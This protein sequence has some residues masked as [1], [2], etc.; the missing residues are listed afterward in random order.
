MSENT[1][2]A[3]NRCLR[4][5][6]QRR[7][8]KHLVGGL[9]AFARWF[10][11]LF[12]VLILIDRFTFLPG[13]ARAVIALAL[14]AVAGRQAWRHGWSRLRGFDATRTAKE[15]EDAQG[16]MDS[17]LVTAVQFQKSGASPGT[18]AAMWELTQRKAEAAAEE[19]P[20]EKVVNLRDLK[21]PIRI[22]AGLA[23]V[24][25]ILAILNG[26]FLAAG[27][28]RLFTPWLAIAYPTKTQ[29]DP[30]AEELVVKEGAPAKVE[31]RLSGSVPTTAKLELQTGE[32]RPR[33]LKLDVADGV[34]VYEIASA[35]RD[36]TYRVKAGDAR[37]DWRQVRV[38]PA[39]RLAEVKVD[40]EYPAYI[41]RPTE[42]VEALTLTVPEETTVRWKLTLD[43]PIQEATLHRDGAEDLPLEIG[44]DGR[45]LTLSE[46]ASASRGYSFSW[47]EAGHGFD[48]T[49]PRY[50]LQVASDQAPRVELT[51]PESNLNAMLGRPLE[52]AVRAQDDHGIGTTTITYRVNRRPEKTI[53][54]A[55]PVRSGE[56]SQA[57]GW[58]YREELPDLQVGDSVS[59]LVEVT[60]KYPGE[61]GPYRARTDSRRIT[62]L[63]RDEYLAAITKQ[64]ERLLTRV[65]TLYRQERAAHELTL[66]LDPGADSYLPTCQLEAI[67]QE[68]VR[69]QLVTT[70]N[71]VQALLDDLAANQVS[72]AVESESLA[73]LRDGLRGIAGDHV[74]RAADLLRQQVGSDTRDPE[75][76]VAA[77]N[78]AAR[79]LAAL[80]LQRDI[81]AAREVFAR[82]TRMFSRQLADLRLRLI[83]SG[84]DQAEALAN[85]HEEVAEWTDTLLDQLTKGMRYDKRP[86]AVLGLSRRIHDLRTGGLSDSI[87]EAAKLAREGKA[88]EAA[89]ANYPLIRPVL[90][91]EFTM[92]SGS[93]YA[94]I[95]ELREQLDSLISGQEE[96]LVTCSELEELGERKAE[97][98]DRQAELRDMLV[99]A[100]LP[101]IPAP[102]TRL[103]DLTMPPAPP[104]DDLRLRSEK[105]MTDAIGQLE[106][107]AKDKA[108]ALQGEAVE[109][110]K[111]LDTIL[112]R[113]SAE[114][115]QQSLGVSALV[116]D[117]TNRAGY[118]D[119]LETRQIGLLEQ[120][121]EA[122][123]DEKNP[124]VLLEDQQALAQD[125]EQFREDLSGGEAGP[126]QEALPLLGR[127][128]AVAEAM[129]LASA[130]LKGKFA[131]EALEPQEEAAAALTEAREIAEGQLVQLNLLQ[132]LISFEQ[133][134]G[135]ASDGMAD[136]VGGQNDLIE[137]TEEADE[138]ALEALLAPQ[139]N[140]LQ[141]LTDIAPSLDLVAA[142][143]DVGTPLVFAASDVEDALLAMEDGDAEDAAEIQDIAVESLAKVQGLVAEISVQTGYVAEIVEFLHEAESDAALLVF[144]QRQLREDAGADDVL[145]KQQALA[146]DTANYGRILTEV[147]GTIDFQ[148]L[149]EKV[150]ERLG[151]LDLTVDFEAPA[152]FMNE[153]VKLIQ[154]GQPAEDAMLAAEKSLA[155]NS[156]QLLVVIT[157]LNGLPAISVTNADPPELHRLIAA[158]DL[159]SKHRQLL[160][161]TQGAADKDLPGLAAGQTKL[162]DAAAK[163]EEGELTHPMVVAAHE[164][165]M[166]IADALR[167]SR[168]ADAARAQ[169][170]ADQTLRHFIIE[171]ALILNTAKPPTSASDEDV[172]TESE[173]DDLYESDTVGF[174]SD[175]V[176]GEAPKDKKSEWEILG[177]RNRA[178][179]NQNFAR[180]L[181]LEYRATL[182]N[183]YERVAK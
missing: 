107:G 75:P 180:E 35:S 124:P 115:A 64:M 144:R 150:R 113:W 17:L 168:K 178:A 77:V 54:L 52:L 15:I 25:L 159:A 131:E 133:S 135:K 126:A 85:G 94:L 155:A 149:D 182:K 148:K 33:E 130:A 22:A 153:A 120:T 8:R 121:E 127:L 139:R 6:W 30:G 156:G 29:I 137:A 160:R 102:R 119:K 152:A 109:S 20:P 66:A 92:R 67:R 63:S 134:V 173:T 112:T 3:L 46:A 43:T 1:H 116:S 39:P 174:V 97:L 90:E 68:M 78:K 91:A 28:G 99:L 26:P 61:G 154:S 166:P 147:A 100:S 89:A 88:A 93:E 95:R 34:C 162:A 49:S 172:L 27:L 142:R 84:P 151:D 58:D 14:L 12:L 13:W 7:Q 59:F 98:K 62:F 145:A 19:V 44:D 157:M 108:V 164:Q 170:A 179:L 183:Y 45:T 105:L 103:F 176:S 101:A 140:L 72:D 47:T 136:I 79:E 9:L 122:A 37:S 4:A 32:G 60:D 111:E 104:T 141:C 16:G 86:L 74:A 42:T 70:A 158:L 114:L 71:E 50:F 73:T 69:E 5:V 51:A 53:T 82:E 48:F 36:F 96:L 132:Q 117:A 10:V 24:L 87:R 143:L 161:D 55:E 177:T 18:S 41:G 129:E 110:L 118:L 21:Q 31:I 165:L 128:E 23:V 57:L 163:L 56:G 2:S 125:I 11:P 80:V 81:D 106:A 175:F 171:Q 40:L 65:R 167:G 76:A 123:L 138:D 146:S 169:A 83:T 38:I 181:P